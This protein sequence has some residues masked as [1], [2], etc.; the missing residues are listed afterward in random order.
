[1]LDGVTG[2]EDSR[3]PP[4][5]AYPGQGPMFATLRCLDQHDPTLVIWALLVCLA[6]MAVG[7]HAYHRGATAAGPARTAWILLTGLVLG[8]GVWATHFIAMLGFQPGLR[9]SFDEPMTALS[10]L[11]ALTGLAGGAGLAMTATGRARRLAGGALCGGSIAAMHFV[12][13]SAMRL[14]A[15]MIWRADLVV[16]AILIAAGLSALAFADLRR[17]SGLRGRAASILLLAAAVCGLHFV[18]MGAVTLLPIADLEAAGRFTRGELARSVVAMVSMIVLA[19]CGMLLTH[20]LAHRSAFATLRSALNRA[21]IGLGYFDRNNLL[22]VWNATLADFARPY[23]LT[24]ARGMSLSEIAERTAMDAKARQAARAV[25]DAVDDQVGEWVSPDTFSSPDGR[26]QSLKLTPAEDGGFLLI[27]TDITEHVTVTEREIEARRLA[28][29]AS[30]AKSEFLANMSHEIR[31][32]LNGI[33]GMTQVMSREALDDDQRE[34]LEIIGASG[35]ALLEILNDVLDLSKIEAGRMEL[36]EAAFDLEETVR[37]ALAPYAPLAAEKDLSLTLA[38]DEAATGAWLGDAPRLRQI[39]GNLVVNAVKF[40]DQGGVAVSVER[41]E[42]GLRFIVA[43]TGEGVSEADRARIF[44]AFTQA[45]A[46]ATRRHGGTGLGL[47]IS[48]SL[49]ERM[50]GGLW[51]ESREG[52]GATFGVDLPLIP[53]AEEPATAVV[54]PVVQAAPQGALRILA[55]EDN[56]VNQTVLQALLA[57]F[58]VELALAADGRQ[59]VAAYQADPAIDL[60]LMDIQMPELN[61]LA[62]AQA[63]RAFEAAHGLAAV[64]IIAV[65]ANA[66]PHQVETYF[67]AGM[68][69]FVAKPLNLAD[70]LAAIEQATSPKADAA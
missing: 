17:E 7:V 62:A 18:G 23:G 53:L 14:P 8:S 52:E 46:S 59:A 60:V 24:L 57:P 55:A 32:P 29:G 39:L 35:A 20:R 69:G 63:I 42:A 33:L 5:R 11:V 43:D 2:Y 15:L 51:L 25:L 26:F 44:K 36:N 68:T 40:T 67:A 9:L 1:M 37:L 16:A 45:D 65:T 21:P 19:G 56:L 64:P 47:T 48:R 58:E 10:F 54:S 41:R 22:Q 38:V 27:I 50:G 49:A 12:G 28:E 4:A 6:S 31:T 13:V 34:R 70:L 30:R 66:M 3:V 61:G